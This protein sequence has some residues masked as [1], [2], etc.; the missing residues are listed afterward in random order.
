LLHRFLLKLT[1]SVRRLAALSPPK[2][3][4]KLKNSPLLFT[5]FNSALDVCKLERFAEGW[6]LSGEIEQHSR[7]TINFRRALIEKLVWFLQHKRLPTCGLHELR[8]FLAYLTHGHEEP[9]GR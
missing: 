5:D 8:L 9:G 7:N 3:G 6:L 4:P 1:A 2:K